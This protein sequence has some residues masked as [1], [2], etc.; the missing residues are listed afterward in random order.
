MSNPAYSKIN[1][2]QSSLIKELNSKKESALLYIVHDILGLEIN[3][4]TGKRITCN[5]DGDM[6]RNCKYYLD[7]GKE[8]EV[9]LLEIITGHPEFIGNS[10]TMKTTYRSQFIISE[11][12]DNSK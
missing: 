12:D 9:L 7:Y 11:G 10:V 1:E 6:L 4:Q 3:E 2:L 5:Y 8:S